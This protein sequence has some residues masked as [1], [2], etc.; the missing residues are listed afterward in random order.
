M[1]DLTIE[2]LQILLLVVLPG[3]VAI[4][5]YDLL[6]P[7]DKRDF[8]GSLG[9]A[10]IYSLLNLAI[11]SWAILPL[12]QEGFAKDHIVLYSFA[13]VGLPAIYGLGE[14]VPLGF[15]YD[16]EYSSGSIRCV[17]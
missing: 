9:E 4:K 8:A 13:S 3:F 2:K 15:R 17:P 16:S 1:P 7:P 5:V 14:V 6:C 11:W 10:V 12:N